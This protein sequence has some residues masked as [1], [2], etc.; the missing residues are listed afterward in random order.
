MIIMFERIITISGS[1]D[2]ILQGV[3]S[4]SCLGLQEPI[5]IYA[6]MLPRNKK[7]TVTPRSWIN[8]PLI[9]VDQSDYHSLDLDEGL[10]ALFIIVHR[11][12]IPHKHA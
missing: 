2:N 10:I 9:V 1:E 5:A 8:L 3:F 4:T 12:S 6:C 11:V 7:K